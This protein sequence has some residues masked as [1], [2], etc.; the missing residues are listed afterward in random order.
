VNGKRV[1]GH[2]NNFCANTF[3]FSFVQEKK[4]AVAEQLT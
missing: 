3:A 2:A 1:I 4:K